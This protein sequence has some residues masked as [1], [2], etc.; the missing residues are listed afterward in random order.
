[1]GLR[2]EIWATYCC[3]NI[4]CYKMITRV[5]ILVFEVSI[6][7]YYLAQ[8]DRIFESSATAFLVTKNGTKRSINI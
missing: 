2:R 7:P 4:F 8:H 1:M 6:E 5:R 3:F